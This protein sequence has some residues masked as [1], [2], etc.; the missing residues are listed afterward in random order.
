MPAERGE[1]AFVPRKV[2]GERRRLGDGYRMRFLRALML[3]IVPAIVSGQ[4]AIGSTR[5]SPLGCAG[6]GFHQFDFWIGR[7]DVFDFGGSARVATATITSVEDGCGLKEQYRGAEG[8]GGES[9]TM[10][11]AKTNLWRQAWVSNRGQIVIIEGGLHDGSIVLSGPE[12]G[13]AAGRWVRGSWTAA[14]GT[15]RETAERSDDAGRT[16]RPWF[17]IVFRRR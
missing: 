5:S 13:G 4:G 12:Y 1:N 9:L 6:E 16:W 3:F 10:Y 8:G 11:D 17:D 7:W 15:V 14:G 2:G